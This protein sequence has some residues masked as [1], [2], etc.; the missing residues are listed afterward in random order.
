VI[1]A[2][3]SVC[4]IKWG[5]IGQSIDKTFDVHLIKNPSRHII[6]IFG[7]RINLAKLLTT[8]IFQKLTKTKIN[9]INRS[10]NASETCF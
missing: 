6:K 2:L 8:K 10:K 4:S 7:A 9:G 3:E 5:T 1:T